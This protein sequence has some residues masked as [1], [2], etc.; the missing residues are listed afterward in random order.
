MPE[1]AS[2]SS[3]DRGP[4]TVELSA[5]QNVQQ[6]MDKALR[7]VDI[8]AAVLL[9]IATVLTAWCAYQSSRW[10]GVQATAFAQA[11]SNRLESSREHTQAIQI[12]ALDADLFT[13]WIDAYATGD[14]ELVDFYMSNVLRTDFIP[15]L[16]EW[17]ELDPLENPDAPRN[18]L[19]NEAYQQELLGES[20]RLRE[21]AEV[22]FTEATEANQ[23]S[24]EYILA[25]VMFASVLFFA[26]ISNKFE[27]LRIQGALVAIA[28]IMI[29]F[30]ILQFGALPVE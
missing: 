25:T 11:S 29:V 16:E 17:I 5:Y 19:G 26:G 30:G 24:D 8:A 12:L 3:S 27:R 22:K 21:L 6:S 10:S 13:R 4:D 18:P 9:A 1:A 14:T 2:P 20:A 23:T 28:F 15:Y 7:Y